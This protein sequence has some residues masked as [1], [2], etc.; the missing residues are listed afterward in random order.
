[1]NLSP[2]GYR[3]KAKLVNTLNLLVCEQSVDRRKG[4]FEIDN[5]KA[6]AFSH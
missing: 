2:L 3:S 5:D 4:V 1:M 6:C